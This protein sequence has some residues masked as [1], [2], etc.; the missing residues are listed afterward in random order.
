MSKIKKDKCDFCGK[1]VDNHCAQQGWIV[2]EGVIVRYLGTYKNGCYQSIFHEK[3]DFDFC[4]FSCL[5]KFIMKKE[6]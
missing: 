1:E 3:R 2:I 6:K 5:Q 4:S